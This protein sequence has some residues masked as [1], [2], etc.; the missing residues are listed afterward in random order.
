MADYSAF[1]PKPINLAGVAALLGGTPAQQGVIN[2]SQ[3]RN[4]SMFPMMVSEG[5]D[6]DNAILSAFGDNQDN[7]ALSAMLMQQ[8]MGTEQRGQNFDLAKVM[9][10]AYVKDGQSM[11]AQNLGPVNDITIDP[12]A[13]LAQGGTKDAQDANLEGAK[14]FFANSS[15]SAALTQAQAAIIAANARMK[16]AGNAGKTKYTVQNLAPGV[17]V[18]GASTPNQGDLADI[19]SSFD[20]LRSQGGQATTQAGQDYANTSAGAGAFSQALASKEDQVVQFV[21]NY[22]DGKDF[23]ITAQGKQFL[24]DPETGFAEKADGTV[25]DTN[26]GNDSSDDQ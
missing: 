17:N 15:G 19:L 6:R 11:Q 4:I 10:P 5:R 9:G 3:G 25:P 16:A 20:N 12:Q 7:N 1:A 23:V 24:V 14:T 2:Q 21:P 13:A 22:K 26:D 18:M 8:A